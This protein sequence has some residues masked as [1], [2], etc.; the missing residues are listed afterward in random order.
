MTSHITRYS[1]MPIPPIEA[2]T[3]YF[4]AGPIRLGVEYRLLSDAVAAAAQ[5]EVAD[6]DERGQTTEL[7]DRGVSIHVFG[8][9]DGEEREFLRFDCFVEDPHYH[10][11]SWRERRNEMLHMDAVATGDPVDFALGCIERRLPALLERAG[12]VDVAQAVDADSL[13]R[14]IPQLRSEAMRLR[15]VDAEKPETSE[16]A[17]R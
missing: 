1:V 4:S 14:V 15:A 9:E 6:G 16:G 11:I 2:H 3:R 10:Y 13:L 5:L 8:T 12:A 17:A 7:D